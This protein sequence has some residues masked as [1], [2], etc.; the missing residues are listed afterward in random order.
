[1]EDVEWHYES[2]G[3]RRGPVSE[4]DMRAMIEDG[5][6]NAET[7]VWKKGFREWTRTEDTDLRDYISYDA[8]PPL[9][10]EEDKPSPIKT[11]FGVIIAI[12]TTVWTIISAILNMVA[13]N[14]RGT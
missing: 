4:A 2:E 14:V 11:V 8:P 9:P 13:R 10:G 7:L 1:M 12:I 3:K 6:T 5:T